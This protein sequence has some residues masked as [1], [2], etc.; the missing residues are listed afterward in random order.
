MA[1]V[2]AWSAGPEGAVQLS[3]LLSERA[4]IGSV[5]QPLPAAHLPLS[6][7]LASSLFP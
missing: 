1:A 7:P 2:S 4:G 6:S 3:E 5:P